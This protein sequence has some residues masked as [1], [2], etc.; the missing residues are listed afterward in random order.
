MGRQAEVNRIVIR[1]EFFGIPRSRTGVPT[2]DLELP[3]PVVLDDV[4]AALR[5]R[6]PDF[7]KDCLTD[8]NL[9]ARF[10]ANIGG[11]RFVRARHTQLI[12]GDSLLILSADAGG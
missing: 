2:V 5:G 4:W 1:V 11:K 6:F 9:D 10:V 12:D 7:A 3:A 8:G